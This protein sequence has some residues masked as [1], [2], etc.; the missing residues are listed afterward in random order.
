VI[1]IENNHLA[2]LKQIKTINEIVSE[3]TQA[4]MTAFAVEEPVTP[5]SPKPQP[6]PLLCKQRHSVAINIRG[7]DK[8]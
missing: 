7:L 5:S 2:I 8:L 3:L 6:S 4:K 1:G